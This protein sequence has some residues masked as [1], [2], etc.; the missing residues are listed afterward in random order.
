MSIP[1]LPKLG[2]RR[3][4]GGGHPVCIR[5]GAR[6][7]DWV[8][9]SG[10][11]T[12]FLG[13]LASIASCLLLPNQPT[14]SVENGRV[15]RHEGEE[16]GGRTTGLAAADGLLF[17]IAV[18]LGLGRACPGFHAGRSSLVGAELNHLQGKGGARA[19]TSCACGRPCRPRPEA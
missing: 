19:R 5:S 10:V 11:R 8:S 6:S 18:A 14:C 12:A 3:A 7:C 2:C 17:L 9:W 4:S 15:G 16:N 1:Q 13:H